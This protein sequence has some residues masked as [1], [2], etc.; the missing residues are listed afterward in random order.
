M[1]IDV[2]FNKNMRK[3]ICSLSK[4]INKDILMPSV[5]TYNLSNIYSMEEYINEHINVKKHKSVYDI[6]RNDGSVIN[7]EINKDIEKIIGFKNIK[8]KNNK[9]DINIDKKKNIIINTNKISNNIDKE[10]DINE[11]YEEFD[12]LNSNIANNYLFSLIETTYDSIIYDYKNVELINKIKNFF[13]IYYNNFIKLYKHILSSDEIDLDFNENIILNIDR[14]TNYEFKLSKYSQ[15][16]IIS[17]DNELT[18]FKKINKEILLNKI[19]KNLQWTDTRNFYEAQDQAKIFKGYDFGDLIEYN[20]YISLKKILMDILEN[21]KH[22]ALSYFF[23]IEDF[24][25]LYDEKIHNK[26]YKYNIYLDDKEY[27]FLKLRYLKDTKDKDVKLIIYKY[28]DELINSSN[29]EN[30]YKIYYQEYILPLYLKEFLRGEKGFYD[31]YKVFRITFMEKDMKTILK[32]IIEKNENENSTYIEKIKID[33]FKYNLGFYIDTIETENFIKKKLLFLDLLSISTREL[34]KSIINKYKIEQ[35][36]YKDISGIHYDFTNIENIDRYFDALEVIIANISSQRIPYLLGR[37]TCRYKD[38]E[39]F[40]IYGKDNTVNVEKDEM[41]IDENFEYKEY[42]NKK[43]YNN[44]FNFG[45]TNLLNSPLA[46]S[47]MCSVIDLFNNYIKMSY[48]LYRIKIEFLKLN[49][50]VSFKLLSMNKNYNSFYNVFIKN[51]KEN[52]DTIIKSFNNNKNLKE[53]P[54]LLKINSNYKEFKDISDE[55]Y[56]V[57]NDPKIFNFNYQFKLK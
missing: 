37:E 15:S 4:Y 57:I 39:C 36:F 22:F 18:F 51:C 50:F 43:D 10:K 29:D 24:K 23:N 49:R 31:F 48:L 11:I 13:S 27:N 47:E 8:K 28:I 2:I 21:D 44:L 16:F 35:K 30:N 20:F 6:K 56:N 7:K 53:N 5:F 34:N 26:N 46:F 3:K 42:I 9:K 52:L 17:S 45:N 1:T 14:E 38:R 55:L 54:N 40:L 41:D 33:F 25:K 32:H 12:L 19:F